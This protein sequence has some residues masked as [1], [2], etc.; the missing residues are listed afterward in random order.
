MCIQYIE[1]S[2]SYFS[3]TGEDTSAGPDSR[4]HRSG[5]PAQPSGDGCMRVCTCVSHVDAGHLFPVFK[6]WQY[7]SFVFYPFSPHF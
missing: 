6:T 5:S 1:E 2:M 7:F 4:G 3:S